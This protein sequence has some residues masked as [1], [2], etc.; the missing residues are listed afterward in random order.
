MKEFL[1]KPIVIII[2]LVVVVIAAW[3]I[4]SSR[5]FSNLISGNRSILPVN[6]TAC[7]GGGGASQL[8]AGI[9]SNGICMPN[10]TVPTDGTACSIGGQPGIYKNGICTPAG[11]GGGGSTNV[12]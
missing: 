6:G 1:S 3:M 10:I 12:S 5:W 11:T 2:I 8:Y 9:Y 7:T 4:G